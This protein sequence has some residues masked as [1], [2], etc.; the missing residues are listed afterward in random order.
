MKKEATNIN[1]IRLLVLTAGFVFSA[2]ISFAQPGLPQRTITVTATQAIHFG[3]FCLTGAGG[4]TVSVGYDG[5]RTSTGDVFLSSLSPSAQ[6]AIF[7]IKLCQGRNVIITYD[8][9]TILTGSNGG[10]FTL[11]IGPTEKGVSGSQFPINNDCS[12]ITTLRVGGTL[13]IPGSSPAG[14]YTGSFHIT[15]EQE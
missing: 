11:D 3:T 8:V 2:S 9:T 6:P 7:D 12:F 5:N 13:N 4:G 15:F 14:V 10:S 1:F